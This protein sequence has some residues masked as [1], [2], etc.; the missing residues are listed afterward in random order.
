MNILMSSPSVRIPDKVAQSIHQMEFYRNLEDM[1]HEVDI[2]A[3]EGSG[4]PREIEVKPVY[5]KDHPLSRPFFTFDVKKKVKRLVKK[6]DYDIIHDRGYLF[7]GAATSVGERYDIPVVL[8]IDDDWV[9]MEYRNSLYLKIPGML[10][11]AKRNCQEMLKKTTMAFTV[12]RTLKKR[13]NYSWGGKVSHIRT[14]PNGVDPKRFRPMKKDQELID[15]L[16]LEGKVMM[17]VGKLGPWHGIDVLLKAFK[18]VKEKVPDMNLLIVGGDEKDVKKYREKAGEGVVF[19]GKIPHKEVPRYINLADVCV[20]PYPNVDYGFCP[21]KILEYMACG[22]PI[23]SSDL[24]SLKEILD[25]EDAIFFEPGDAEDL[26]KKT[27]RSFDLSLETMGERSR[28]KV[29]RDYTWRKSTE[30]LVEVYREAVS[31]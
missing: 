5:S 7:G 1:G 20:A 8:Q 21:F 9:E 19:T 17:F 11:I 13:I 30:Q 22:K 28:E 6:N 26:A 4:D 10:N 31:L 27:I 15:R 12:S 29:E 18:S 16:G 3:Q 2:L 23:I 14:V 24:P 25:E